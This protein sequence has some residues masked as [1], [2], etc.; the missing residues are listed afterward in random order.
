MSRSKTG[1]S[2]PAPLRRELKRV[3]KQLARPLSHEAR[4]H[5]EQRERELVDGLE[6]ITGKNVAVAATM[7]H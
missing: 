4:R 5:W 2:S 6:T 7:E 3:R 1:R